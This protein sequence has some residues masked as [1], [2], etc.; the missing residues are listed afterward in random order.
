MKQEDVTATGLPEPGITFVKLADGGMNAMA[1]LDTYPG[2]GGLEMHVHEVWGADEYQVT[3]SRSGL[4]VTFTASLF[5]LSAMEQACL[6]YV[7]R[8][9]SER[10]WPTMATLMD[11]P[12]ED[13]ANRFLVGVRRGADQEE[14][15]F[16]NK[17]VP[18][19]LT[20]A[21]AINL[22]AWLA[23]M[24]DPGGQEFCKVYNKIKS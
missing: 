17:V 16:I 8:L 2:I 19:K 4:R 14:E 21:A 7:Q 20:R 24:A 3:F 10:Q 12:I 18:S 6:A 1:Y 5:Q 13:S 9:R 22:A 11:G 15:V 23:L